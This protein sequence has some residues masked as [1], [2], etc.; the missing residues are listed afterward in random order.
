MLKSEQTVLEQ[1]QFTNEIN[2]RTVDKKTIPENNRNEIS[3]V[4]EQQK[5]FKPKQMVVEQEQ[6]TNNMNNR[7]VDKNKQE[8]TVHE[9][10]RTLIQ[11][12]RGA[13]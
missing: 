8:Y 6:I 3:P 11:S 12:R 1:K 2:N 10:D 9:N 7:T 5:I 4:A 13:T